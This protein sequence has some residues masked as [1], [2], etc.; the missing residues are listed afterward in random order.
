MSTHAHTYI[1]FHQKGLMSPTDWQNVKII[2]PKIETHFVTQS[3]QPDVLFTNN[4]FYIFG[5]DFGRIKINGKF[6]NLKWWKN[7][8]F[9]DQCH[10]LSS[11]IQ[12][13]NAISKLI[14]IKFHRNEMKTNRHRNKQEKKTAH[15]FSKSKN[16]L[17]VS[18]FGNSNW[19]KCHTANMK[20]R[21]LH[22]FP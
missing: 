11:Q 19:T 20:M 12:Q 14:L 8:S 17:F 6:K 13:C 16:T 3:I 21:I 15:K 9:K 2:Q 7:T 10:K 22:K 1:K 4:W 5:T 18:V